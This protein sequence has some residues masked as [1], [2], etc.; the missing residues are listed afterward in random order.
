MIH[1]HN[2]GFDIVFTA[3]KLDDCGFVIDVGQLQSVKKFLT[4]AF[5]H[6]LLVNA[7]DPELKDIL[8]NEGRR[9]NIKLLQNCGMEGIAKMV[10]DNVETI[11]SEDF[12]ESVSYRDLQVIS[13]TCWEDSKNSSTYRR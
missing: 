6:T 2:W 7:D 4:E 8:A 12:K 1:G 10:F 11:L 9:S 5:D 3:E 13:V